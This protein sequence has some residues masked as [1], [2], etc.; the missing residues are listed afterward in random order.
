MFEGLVKVPIRQI[1]A[2]YSS[3]I[4]RTQLT[5]K[6]QI[7]HQRDQCQANEIAYP[8]AYLNLYETII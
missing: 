6:N 5:Y 1:S 7:M 8:D 2:G 3:L 4:P